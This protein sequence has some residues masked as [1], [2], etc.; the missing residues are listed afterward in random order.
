VSEALLEVTDLNVWLPSPHTGPVHVVR[1]ISLQI[2][3]G[4]RLG[5]VGESGCGKSTAV[6]ALL[7]LLPAG[8]HV[9]GRVRFAGTDLLGGATDGAAGLSIHRGREMTIVLQ[10]SMN[11][12]NPV[13]RVDVQLIEAMRP[14]MRSDARAHCVHL[15]DRVGLPARVARAY[16][17]ELSGGMRQR[18]AIAMALAPRPRL[19]IADEPT[20]ALDTVVQARIIELL[21]SVC[22]ETSMAVVLVSHHLPLT[23]GFCDRL[24]VMYGGLIIE[25]GVGEEICQQP[26]HPYTRLLF[27]ATADLGSHK[28]EIRSIAGS[29][30]S[31]SEAHTRCPFLAR[32]PDALPRC[33]R[34][35]PPPLGTAHGDGAVA[36]YV[37]DP[38]ERAA[39]AAGT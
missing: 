23:A 27:E 3:A 6:M 11:A 34:D 7:G 36:C 20:T 32:C 15:L 35:G 39:D 30:P 19:L 1:G 2:D 25:H 24:S 8:S 22:A 37:T 31:P 10:A 16:A 12:L 18:V 4:Q 13:R 17:H 5:L 14:E 38:A 9:S 26:A 28:S 29:P 21:D 33:R